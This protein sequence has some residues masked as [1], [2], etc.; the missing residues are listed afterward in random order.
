MF[1]QFTNYIS[2]NYA[3]TQVSVPKKLIKITK[4]PKKG[5]LIKM[6]GAK[7]VRQNVMIIPRKPPIKAI[8]Y[9]CKNKNKNTCIFVNKGKDRVK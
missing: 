9:L 6:P 3:R 8:P 1:I 2:Y 5:T 7:Q 4:N